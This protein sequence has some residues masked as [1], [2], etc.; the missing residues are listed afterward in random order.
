MSDAR[1]TS[2]TSGVYVG[3]NFATINLLWERT[4]AWAPLLEFRDRAKEARF[5]RW[6]RSH[7]VT[8]DIVKCFITMMSSLAFHRRVLAEYTTPPNTLPN[9][10]IFFGSNLLQAFVA[11][12]NRRMYVRHRTSIMSVMRLLLYANSLLIFIGVAKVVFKQGKGADINI[13]ADLHFILIGVLQGIGMHLLLRTLIAAMAGWGIMTV[14]CRYVVK[15][16]PKI[17]EAEG[18]VHFFQAEKLG[19]TT[20][21]WL[22]EKTGTEVLIFLYGT[23]AAITIITSFLVEMYC[24][25]VF[26]VMQEGADIQHGGGRSETLGQVLSEAEPT[27]RSERRRRSATTRR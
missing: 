16:L 9:T 1:G 13:G 3:H 14:I 23:Y 10:L 12:S 6:H 27:R 15:D 26:R 4:R 25:R 17:S 20:F 11:V 21:D 8:A 18:V 19:L 7:M 5:E 2:R 24:R 22:K